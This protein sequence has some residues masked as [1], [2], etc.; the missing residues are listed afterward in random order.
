MVAVTAEPIAAITF[1]AELTAAVGW[2]PVQVEIALDLVGAKENVGERFH[3]MLDFHHR[4]R[5]L[6][7][8]V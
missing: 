2:P 8:P 4:T 6:A 3:R 1:V 5:W 7:A